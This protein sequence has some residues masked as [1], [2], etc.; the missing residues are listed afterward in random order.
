MIGLGHPLVVGSGVAGLTVAL[1]LPRATILTAGAFGSTGYA[2]GGIAAALGVDDDPALH[3]DDTVGVAGGLAVREAVDVLTAGGPAAIRRLVE[4][5]ARFDAAPAGV[6]ALG[7]EAGHSRRRIVHADGDATG[8]EV[9]RALTA[10]VGAAE[11]VEVWEGWHVV[12]LLRDGHRVTGVL[13]ADRTGVRREVR[14]PAVV[15]ATGGIGRL[16]L[17][18][19]NPP[20]VT[21]EGIAVAARAGARLADL[22]LVQ[23]HPT[24]LDVGVDPLPLLTEALRGE[25]ALL[26]DGEG[27]RFMLRHHAAAELA[28]RDVVARAIWWQLDRGAGA[29]L[30]A[31]RLDRVGER[32]PTVSALCAAAGLDPAADL[33]P[34]SPAAHYYMGGIDTDSRGRTS[35]AG[36]WAVGECASTGVHGAN[37]LASNSLLEGLV[38]GARAA[39]DVAGADLGPAGG[40][41]APA[42]AYELAADPVPEIEDVRRVMWERV[43]LVRTGSGLWEARNRLLDLEPALSRSLPGRVAFDV[44]RL[45]VAAAL[46]RSESRGSHFRADYPEPD[47]FQEARNLVE[48][49]PEPTKEPSP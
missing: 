42:V 10:A 21:G 14:A 48:P 2:Q 27:R 17:R 12:G 15:L 40:G 45:V 34:V 3:A 13:A 44:A 7:R 35:L 28:P 9:L 41:S 1:G 8:R 22:E 31:R 4:L 20:G 19:T 24:A 23:F 37:R 43:G 49:V 16:F 18:T 32:F 33:L 11:T 26:V 29:F 36:L 5:G 39:A 25:G 38:F 6:L 46:R 47:P 30:D